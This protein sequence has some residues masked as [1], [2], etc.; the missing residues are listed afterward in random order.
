MTPLS[1]DELTTRERWLIEQGAGTYLAV[2]RSVDGEL[3]VI[4]RMLFTHAILADLNDYGYEQRWCYSDFAAAAVAFWHWD[5]KDGTEPAGWHRHPATG[6]RVS[7]DGR[8][9][10]AP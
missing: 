7:E 8:E 1:K 10:V 5:G 4:A 9:Y 6:R 2:G 3:C